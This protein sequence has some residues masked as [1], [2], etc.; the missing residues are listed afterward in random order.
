MLTPEQKRNIPTAL[1]DKYAE[2]TEFILRDIASRIAEGARLTDTAEYLLYRAKALGLSEKAIAAKIAE[3][4]GEAAETIE[5]LIYSAADTADRNDREHLG[6]SDSIETT[7]N[8]PLYKL[9]KAQ[10]AY[11]QSECEN[12]TNTLGFADHNAD[13]TVCYRSLTDMYRRQMDMAQ[14]K[15]AN[16]V[17]DYTTALRQAVGKLAASG[18]RTIDY[19]SGCSRTVEAATRNALMTSISQVTNKISEQNAKELGADGWEM[20]AHSGAR[21]SH[22]VYQGRQYTQEEY[23]RKIRGLLNDYGCRHD[24][25]PVIL[26]VSEPVYTEQELQNIDPPPFTYEGR[27]YT[28]YEAQ[29]QMRKMERAMRKQKN[30]CI[31]ADASGDDEAFTT[32]SIKLRRQKDIYEDFCKAADSYTQYER[33]FVG[34]YNRHLSGRTGAVTRRQRAFDNAQLRLDNDVE[35]VYNYMGNEHLFASHYK[36]GVLDLKSA[37]REYDDFLNN[38]VPKS[39]MKLLKQYS[40]SVKYI[41]TDNQDIL[42][43]YSPRN[44]FFVYNPRNTQ[45]ADYDLNM[46]L[47]HEIAHRIDNKLFRSDMQQVFTEAISKYGDTLDSKSVAE[48]INGSDTLSQN[49][50]LQDIMSAVT[51]GHIPL[52]AGHEPDYW[53]RQGKRQKEIFANIFTLECFNDTEALDFVKEALPDVYNSYITMTAKKLGRDTDGITSN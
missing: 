52:A 4:N 34:G 49:A 18:V 33:T 12:L 15:V 25:Y 38:S 44:D 20:S 41:T 53:N 1:T 39:H 6:I 5:Q 32:A 42:M 35:K 7:D 14:L 31:V 8:E 9:M 45:L 46:S 40:Y 51:G 13:G 17:T 30:R 50:P 28:A 3:I 24:V 48:K 19:E 47:T 43:G 21:P 22:A 36:N 11:T 10:V 27:R 26:G 2:L 29:Q 37:R 16:G 23:E